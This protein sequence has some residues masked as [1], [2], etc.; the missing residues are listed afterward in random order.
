MSST[1]EIK[2]DLT[3]RGIRSTVPRDLTASLNDVFANANK[4]LNRLVGLPTKSR[5]HLNKLKS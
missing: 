2:S 3:P 4:E 5:S 1:N